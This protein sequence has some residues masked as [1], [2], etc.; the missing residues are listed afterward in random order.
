MFK[1]VASMYTPTWTSFEPIEGRPS[2]KKLSLG[3]ASQ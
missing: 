1:Q 3:L 2:R